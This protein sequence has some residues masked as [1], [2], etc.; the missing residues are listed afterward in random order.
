MNTLNLGLRFL[1][2]LCGL[3]AIGYWGW[4]QDVGAF[5]FVLCLVGPII[6]GIAWFTFNVKNDPSRS[7]K[8]PIPV[9]GAVRLALELFLFGVAVTAAYG[10]M[11]P[12]IGIVFGTVVFIHYVASYRRVIWMLQR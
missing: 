10:S 12:I 9:P 6:F 1:L 4:R 2:E 5:R 8:A 11:S 7:G 3:F